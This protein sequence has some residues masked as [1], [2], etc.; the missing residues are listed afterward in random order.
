[1]R[2]RKFAPKVPT[3]ECHGIDIN[4][5]PV[6]NVE[7]EPPHNNGVSRLWQRERQSNKIINEKLNNGNY[8]ET[9]GG[10]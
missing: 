1:M 5:C 7:L 10:A 8:H 4:E 2:P 9:E 6:I 3:C